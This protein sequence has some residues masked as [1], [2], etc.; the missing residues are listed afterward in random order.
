MNIMKEVKFKLAQM[1]K[2]KL[3]EVSTDKGTLYYEGD[4]DVGT[5][6]RAMDEEG[7]YVLPKDGEYVEGSRIL[8]VVNGVVEGIEDPSAAG[9]ESPIVVENEDV[10]PDDVPEPVVGDFVPVE[11][12]NELVEVVKDL[13][14]E[15]ETVSVEF[16][17][18]MQMSR[19]DF[20]N[21]KPSV[22]NEGI[23]VKNESQL[24][25]FGLK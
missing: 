19:Q 9:E 4:L 15:L 8:T 24:G 20:A 12:F 21:N 23:A 6:V 1:T 3:A 10:S 14:E 5:E 16:K 11:T 7:T 25:K 22:K 2:I 17:T 13:A 18:A